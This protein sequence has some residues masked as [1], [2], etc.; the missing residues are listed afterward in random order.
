MEEEKQGYPVIGENLLLN[1]IVE[2]INYING[3][4]G[5]TEGLL[6]HLETMSTNWTVFRSQAGNPYSKYKRYF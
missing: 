1:R 3:V 4:N 5:G 6:I 2:S